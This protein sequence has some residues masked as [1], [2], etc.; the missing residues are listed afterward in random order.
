M[1]GS[2]LVRDF[3]KSHLNK[4]EVV[5]ERGAILK[6]HL[7]LAPYRRVNGR[8]TEFWSRFDATNSPPSSDQT[9]HTFR[10]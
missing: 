1:L 3:F 9:G 10:F 4:D 8:A 7:S 6:Y 2:L 5:R